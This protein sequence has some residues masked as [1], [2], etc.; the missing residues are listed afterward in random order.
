MGLSCRALLHD[1]HFPTY[2]YG[3]SPSQISA[4]L[5]APAAAVTLLGTGG[6]VAV[7]LVVFMAATSAAS[8]E[9]IAVSSILTFDVYGSFRPVSGSK[10]VTISH[11][12]IIMFAVWA[13][14][15]A[16]IL[17]TIK[18]DLGWLYYVQGVVL[19]PAVFPIASTVMWKRQSAN[20]AFFGTMIGVVCG[21]TGWMVG[22][23]MIYG[24]ISIPNLALP[25]SAICGSTPGLLFS[26][27][28]SICIT[29]ISQSPLPELANHESPIIS[30]GVLPEALAF[31]V[32]QQSAIRETI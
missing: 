22:C 12:T 4:G 8:A 3:L 1:P 13:G 23:K 2:P 19:T 10:A 25:Y 15:W 17:H 31:A 24:S 18:V 29:W 30:T 32:L 5:S 26:T 11:I 21:M 14:A 28:T 16:T 20:A 27:L 7:L 9:L 6:A